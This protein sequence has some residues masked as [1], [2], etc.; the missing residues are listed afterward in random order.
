LATASVLVNVRLR[1]RGDE[2]VYLRGKPQLD[3]F[4]YFTPIMRGSGVLQ[5]PA[6]GSPRH[7]LRGRPGVHGPRF[8]DSHQ[9]ATRRHGRPSPAHQKRRGTFPTLPI[10]SAGRG[11]S[12]KRLSRREQPVRQRRHYSYLFRNRS[13]RYRSCP[14]GSPFEFKP[15]GAGSGGTAPVKRSP[16]TNDLPKPLPL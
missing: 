6:A 16:S 2:H 11:R 14:A 7:P 3:F 15:S 1:S 12:T 8:P 4:Q 5:N 10:D 9:D 13:T